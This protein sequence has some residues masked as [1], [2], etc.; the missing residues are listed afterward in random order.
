[1]GKGMDTRQLMND[2][3]YIFHILDAI[4]WMGFQVKGNAMFNCTVKIRWENLYG[5]ALSTA[6]GT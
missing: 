4:I 1:M 6:H 5:G 2:V 3:G